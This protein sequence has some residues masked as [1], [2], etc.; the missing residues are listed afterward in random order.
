MPIYEYIC[1]TCQKDEEN[2]API[3]ILLLPSEV[4]DKQY[5]E[6]CKTELTRI[7][8]QSE[9]HLKGVG[10]A[11]HGYTKQHPPVAQANAGRPSRK[12]YK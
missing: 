9:F 3:E 8:S 12:N 6:V 1:K 10:W 7:I 2:A 11:K 4:D 5:C